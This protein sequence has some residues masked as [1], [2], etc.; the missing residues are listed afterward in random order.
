MLNRKL[1]ILLLVLFFYCGYAFASVDSSFKLEKKYISMKKPKIAEMIVS[2]G[3]GKYPKSIKLIYLRG[4]IRADWL[5]KNALALIDYNMVIKISPNYSRKI[6]W[7]IGDLYYSY[8]KYSVAIKYYTKCLSLMPKNDKVYL[9]RAKALIKLGRK[10]EAIRDVE[11]CLI[12]N[13]AYK[14]LARKI[15]SEDFKLN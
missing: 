10:Q 14:I 12:I 4:K 7:R 15:L 8:A 2:E 5:F 1:L 13:P 6:Y 11:R 9:K 3:I